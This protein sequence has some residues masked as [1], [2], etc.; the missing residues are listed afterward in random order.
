MHVKLGEQLYFALAKGPLCVPYCKY[1][2]KKL[3]QLRVILVRLI[4]VII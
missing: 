1:N 2:L 3:N 4:L